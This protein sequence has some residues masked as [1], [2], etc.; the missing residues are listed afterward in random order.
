MN[1]KKLV[2]R[3]N[4]LLMKVN[5]EYFKNIIEEINMIASR[6]CYTGFAELYDKSI[7]LNL[8]A[9]QLYSFL[10]T[11]YY[12]NLTDEQ[13]LS[14]NRLLR[15]DLPSN[16]Q[17]L[18]DLGE[19]GE[20]EYHLED[21]ISEFQN[22]THEFIKYYNSNLMSFNQYQDSAPIIK[23][24]KYNMFI[25]MID[26]GQDE[27]VT[28][29]LEKGMAIGTTGLSSCTAIFIFGMNQNNETIVSCTHASL[30]DQ[31]LISKLKLKMKKSHNVREDTFKVYLIGGSI[32]SFPDYISLINDANEIVDIRLCIIDADAG[33]DGAAVITGDEN[34]IYYTKDYASLPLVNVDTQ[35]QIKHEKSVPLTDKLILELY[36]TMKEV[37]DKYDPY[38]FNQHIQHRLNI[39]TQIRYNSISTFPQYFFSNTPQNQAVQIIP[40]NYANPAVYRKAKL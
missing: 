21:D 8:V 25:N 14:C 10:S 33:L 36:D 18:M 15:D 32:S 3:T 4:D 12:R 2:E 27:Q 38:Y 34:V 19:D 9:N 20:T 35:K 24:A 17:D 6:T 1:L 39:N 30:I 13:K 5:A 11:D 23:V 28:I 22:M 16:L 37:I 26:V 29:V 7:I 40:N 31:H